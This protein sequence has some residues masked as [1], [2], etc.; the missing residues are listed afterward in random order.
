MLQ[1]PPKYLFS[2]ECHFSFTVHRK[3][4]PVPRQ[5]FTDKLT[6]FKSG[7]QIMFTFI[8]FDHITSDALKIIPFLSTKEILIIEHSSFF[9]PPQLMTLIC[10][11][12]SVKQGDLSGRVFFFL[13][14]SPKV[15]TTMCQAVT[16]EQHSRIR[17]LLG[18]M[19]LL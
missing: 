2:I 1:S 18:K 11:M 12:A 3:C 9:H 7:G 8:I 14:S 6:L 13:L 16:P 10:A 5:S 4:R 19:G 17:L 15:K